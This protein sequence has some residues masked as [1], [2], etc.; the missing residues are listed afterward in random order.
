M[1]TF[2]FVLTLVCTCGGCGHFGLS[3]SHILSIILIAAP[4][5][6]LYTE[7]CCI[8]FSKMG[9]A[10]FGSFFNFNSSSNFTK[11]TVCNNIVN[12]TIANTIVYGVHGMGVASTFSLTTLKFLVNRTINH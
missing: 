5:T 8:V 2:N 3:V 12:T 4:I 7:T 11:L 10:D 6:V 9:L 1:V